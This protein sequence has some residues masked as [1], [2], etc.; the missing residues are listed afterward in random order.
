M[1]EEVVNMNLYDNRNTRLSTAPSVRPARLLWALD[2]GLW[3]SKL[4]WR[5]QNVNIEE[6]SSNLISLFPRGYCAGLGGC[7]HGLRERDAIH[8]L[9]PCY[10][11]LTSKAAFGNHSD[12]FMQD[13]HSSISELLDAF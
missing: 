2:F 8:Q 7:I 3:L 5:A 6:G 13:L 11:A 10:E 9:E 1:K 12:Q 4:L